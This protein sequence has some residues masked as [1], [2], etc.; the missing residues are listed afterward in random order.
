MH[1]H[2]PH[3]QP[4]NAEIYVSPTDPDFA[5]IA[6][7]AI[8]RLAWNGLAYPLC[9]A[10]SVV[11]G[12]IRGLDH[13]ILP[14]IVTLTGVCVFRVIWLNTAFAAY[15][16]LECLFASYPISWVMTIIAHFICYAAIMKKLRRIPVHVKN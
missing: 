11:S 14:M 6:D 7:A 12:M 10:M 2:I 5:A 8:V 3:R 15:P 16:T 9:G 4:I 1:L 13:P